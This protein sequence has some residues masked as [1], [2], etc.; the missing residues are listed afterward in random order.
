MKER[1]LGDIFNALSSLSNSDYKVRW[2]KTLGDFDSSK[3]GNDDLWISEEDGDPVVKTFNNFIIQDG[4]IISPTKRCKGLYLNILG[5]CTING[6]LSMTARGCEAK[7]K[8]VSIFPKFGVSFSDLDVLL[9]Y[10]TL[11]TTLYPTMANDNRE[12]KVNPPTSYVT[13]ING[14]NGSLGVGGG[15]GTGRRLF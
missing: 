15:G 13:K 10:N 9:K 11:C 4:D 1:Y 3:Q 14:G 7:G 6:I 12:L 5:N 2:P 8:Y